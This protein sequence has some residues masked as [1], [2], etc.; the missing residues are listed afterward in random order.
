MA[1]SLLNL[2]KLDDVF[3][4]ACN[5]L[6]IADDKIIETD[7]SSSLNIAHLNIHSILNK[8]HDLI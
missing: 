6:D 1:D 4:S 8:Y 5:Y 3:I 2:V 7:I